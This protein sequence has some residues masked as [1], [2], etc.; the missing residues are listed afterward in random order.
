MATHSRS[1]GGG[2]VSRAHSPVWSATMPVLGVAGLSS[3]CRA[4][5]EK[6]VS[7]CRP[8]VVSSKI[9]ILRKVGMLVLAGVVSRPQHSASSTSRSAATYFHVR[10]Q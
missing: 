1:S 4:E 7:S 5:I 9:L 6:H 10:H 2:C 8:V 3:S